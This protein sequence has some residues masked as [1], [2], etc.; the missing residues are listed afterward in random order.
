MKIVRLELRAFGPF[1]DV[2]LDLASAA[3]FEGGGL[4]IVY[5]PNEA[6]KSSALRALLNFLYGIPERTNDDFIH[7]YRDLRIGGILTN[8]SAER[9]VCV[10]RKARSGD[11]RGAD[12]TEP[13]DPATLDR[14]LGGIDRETFATMFGI[15]HAALVAGGRDIVAGKGNLGQVL[16]AAGSGLANLKAIQEQLDK[17]AGELFKPAGKNQRINARLSDWEA[18]RRATKAAQLTTA[19]WER[20]DGLL[21]ESQAK[22][23]ETSAALE[24]A[25]VEHERLKRIQQAVPLAARLRDTRERLAPL[26]DARLLADDFAERRREAQAGRSAAERTL[27]SAAE[28]VAELD[29][30]IAEL[31]VPDELIARGEA[32]EQLQNDLG[33]Y[34]QARHDLPHRRADASRIE[35]EAGRLLR[36][37]RPDVSLAEVET[38]RLTKKARLEIQNL[39]NRHEGLLTRLQT[40]RSG[41]RSIEDRLRAAQERLTALEAPRDAEPLKSVLRRAEG[42]GRLQEELIAARDE[43]ARLDGRAS[44][45]L[46]RLAGW[47]GSLEELEKLPVPAAE[48]IDA[49]ET[50]FAQV[51]Q[52]EHEVAKAIEQAE[53][54]QA[55]CDR[56]LKQARL[57]GDV[58]SEAELLDARRR[59]DEGWQLICRSWRDG[60]PQ[61][62]EEARF[63]ASVGHYGTLAD[64]FTEAVR[65][66]DELAD[67]LRREADRVARHAAQL[68]AHETGKEALEKLAQRRQQ[69]AAQRQATETEWRALWQ[70]VGVE[71][72]SPREMRAWE[73]ACR[74]LAMQA[75]TVRKER[76]AIAT[77]QERLERCRQELERTLSGLGEP[78]RLPDESLSAA[79]ERGH[80][81]A[82]RIDA[83]TGERARLTEEIALHRRQ[84]DAERLATGEAERELASWLERWSKA[85]A[86]LGLPADATPEQ[87]NEV[88]GQIDDLFNALSERDAFERR[89][90]EIGRYS[91]SF[92]RQVSDLIVALG[93]SDDLGSL[94]ADQAADR[95]LAEYRRG[96]AAEGRL[97]AL[98]D[99]RTKHLEQS[100]KASEAAATAQSSMAAL[101]QEAACDDEE[102]LPRLEELSIQAKG[103]RATVQQIQE[104]LVLLSAGAPLADFLEQV[105]HVDADALPGKLAQLEERI[106]E[107]SAAQIQLSETVGRQSKVLAD[108]GASEAA[109]EAECQARHLAAEI[110][111]DAEEYARLRLAAAVL[112]EALERYRARHQGP[113]LERASRLFAEL[114]AGSFAGLRADYTDGGEAVLVGVRPGDGRAVAVEGMSDG[115]ADQ[116][117]LALRL[118]SLEIWLAEKGP[119]PF[120]IDDI[121]IK[122]DNQRSVATLRVLAELARQT[123]V[124]FFTHHEHLLDLA[125]QH[126][127][128]ASFVVHRLGTS[129]DQAIPHT[130][131]KRQR[132]NHPLLPL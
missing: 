54:E 120:V 102:A 9:L 96:T 62:A 85:V 31:V 37:L 20:E 129:N 58:P 51:V 49:F 28:A 68:A 43:L 132:K 113:V 93:R 8:G 59:R 125:R 5:G 73:R 119:M 34:R 16:F 25:R 114:T 66:A 84:L 122:F 95:L 106:A 91:Q 36:Q 108:M 75:E 90:E 131:P 53:A 124:V 7:G 47:T 107:L 24:Q 4:H 26:A 109:A 79:L 128:P 15:D 55:E 64:A 6:G 1:R 27:R 116:L 19:E 11:L 103:L 111:T 60:A 22:L 100:A 121:L 130:K 39:G 82:R 48:S 67:R 105:G 18:A 110:A 81:L 35:V 63:M 126:L 33:V 127:P 117:Y 115:T 40:A 71:P 74:E 86:F 78:A 123:Q 69:T 21:R 3:N 17:E 97:E 45:A 57:A 98:R 83:A 92:E 23:A 77:L 88:L 112:R 13:L 44:A 99:Q 80:V 30:Q 38:L 101:H 87:A 56:Q 29:A 94:A 52:H 46:A 76:S 2:S 14:Y 42:V 50:R 32:I 89:I 12:D 72:R 61:P 104:Q 41:V 65:Q 70:P 118:A 10:R